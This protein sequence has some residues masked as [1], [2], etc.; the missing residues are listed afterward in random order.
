MLSYKNFQCLLFSL[1]RTLPQ[2]VC[3]TKVTSNGTEDIWKVLSWHFTFSPLS[4]IWLKSSLIG[5]S[6]SSLLF[7]D[8]SAPLSCSLLDNTKIEDF[9]FLSQTFKAP[10]DS[11]LKRHFN[12][13]L[14]Y[15]LKQL[16]RL[17]YTTL[18]I[19]IK[20]GWYSSLQNNFLLSCLK[21]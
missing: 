14:Q 6:H 21:S 4:R 1:L 12:D 15:Y 2:L 11:V 7:D 10:E 20:H 16:G 9:N 8:Y 18:F 3:P 5:A 17:Q 19:E 13:I